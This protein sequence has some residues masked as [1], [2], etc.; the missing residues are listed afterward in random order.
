MHRSIF[1][2]GLSFPMET[3]VQET[4]K[5][6]RRINHSVIEKRRREK[7]NMCLKELQNLVPNCK[8]ENLQKLAILERT[9]EYLYT[10]HKQFPDDQSMH[11]DTSEDSQ[12]IMKID[13]LLC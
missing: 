5:E 11:S 7:I 12:S 8:D 13:N 6:K 1:L 4:R 3:L 10:L 9:V 2:R